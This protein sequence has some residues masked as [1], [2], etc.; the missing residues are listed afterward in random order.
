[1][2]KS[3]LGKDVFAVLSYL[4]ICASH[5][6]QMQSDGAIFAAVEA[7]GYFRSITKDISWDSTY[8]SWIKKLTVY[9]FETTATNMKAHFPLLHWAMAAP[10]RTP[11][12]FVHYIDLCTLWY[13]FSYL[14]VFTLLLKFNY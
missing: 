13:S 5:F 14:F 8:I 6:Q 12:D 3:G 11:F 1:M 7:Q 4:H 2:D 10:L 9:M